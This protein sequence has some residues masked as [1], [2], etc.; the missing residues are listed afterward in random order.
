M[1]V[2]CAWCGTVLAD[3]P[4]PVSHGIC[5][6]CLEAQLAALEAGRAA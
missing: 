3:G 5:E 6:E 4:P 2:E 1:R